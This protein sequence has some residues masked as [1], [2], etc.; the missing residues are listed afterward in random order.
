MGS[1]TNQI[2]SQQNK[3]K[4]WFL[5]RGENRRTQ[6]KNSWKRVENQQTQSM[7]DSGSGNRTRDTLVEG[8]CSHHNANPPH[9][10]SFDQWNN[11]NQC[12][13]QN[14]LKVHKV[15][16]FVQD[17]NL[18]YLQV[19][20][21]ASKTDKNG[22]AQESYWPLLSTLKQSSPTLMFLKS[23]LRSSWWDKAIS[24]FNWCY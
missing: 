5:V 1:S 18:L 8:E 19:L 10:P 14:L 20:V 7:Y 21:L 24:T 13:C 9:E 16:Y 3:F 11:I 6:E 12:T 2:K 4:C 15:I 23:Q 22:K 17:F